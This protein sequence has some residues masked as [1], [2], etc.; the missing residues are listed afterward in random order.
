MGAPEVASVSSSGWPR[1]CGV[2]HRTQPDTSLGSLSICCPCLGK[3]G[4]GQILAF[5]SGLSAPASVRDSL[6]CCQRGD[7]DSCQKRPPTAMSQ[8]PKP[9]PPGVPT[10]PGRALLEAAFWAPWKAWPNWMR[11]LLCLPRAVPSPARDAY[12]EAADQRPSGLY[13]TSLPLLP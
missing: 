9:S 3:L 2:L 6:C 7:L 1:D 10:R 11:L 8:F 12:P 4:R 5:R 13:V